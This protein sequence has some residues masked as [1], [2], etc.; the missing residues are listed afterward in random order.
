MKHIKRWETSGLRL[1]K[2]FQEGTAV[3]IDWNY[4]NTCSIHF[5]ISCYSINAFQISSNNI[6]VHFCNKVDFF[7]SIHI[8]LETKPKCCP[9]CFEET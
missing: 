1:Q 8:I 6:A 2:L 4:F 5:R 7:R 9:Q 3:F